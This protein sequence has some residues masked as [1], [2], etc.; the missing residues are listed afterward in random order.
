MTSTPRSPLREVAALAIPVSLEMVVALV[1][2]FI[3]Q[4]VVGGL[5]TTAIA[6]VGFANS[7]TFIVILTLGAL[8]GSVSI[9]AA[10]AHGGGR[11]HELNSLVHVA[12]FVGLGVSVLFA[13]LPAL[14]PA[15]VLRLAGG[16][17]T[18]VETGSHY[19]RFTAIGLLPLIANRV[20]AGVMRST[21]HTRG[22]LV[23]TTVATVFN[24]LLGYALVYGIGPF[25]SLG[26]VGAGVASLTASLLNLTIVCVMAY[27]IDRI[28]RWELPSTAREWWAITKPL[29]VFA[30]PLALTELVW[31]LGGY[32]YNVIFQRLGDEALAA[33]QVAGTLEAVF[34]L[35]SFGLMTAATTLIG[36]SIGQGDAGAA[37]QWVRR[38]MKAGY[39]TAAV[40]GLLY[41]AS[42]L[43]L[44]PLFP[45]VD[46]EVRHLAAVAIA[47]NAAF[48]WAKVQNMVLGGGLLPGG[49]DLKAVVLGDSVGVGVAGLPLAIGLGL[50]TPLGFIGV[51]IGRSAE[52]LLK[53]AIFRRRLRR[54]DWESLAREHGSGS[55][56]GI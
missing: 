55:G 9:M 39:A 25:P 12:L 16:S 50:F 52:E 46:V 29:F 51:L 49:N 54:I 20:I 8:G 11:L 53:L 17:P 32:F 43:I 7:I 10:R 47:I 35:A 41:L 37:R 21:G 24:T 56:E 18:V 3:N 22:P 30:A 15:A 34:I 2:N 5:G 33:A 27:G 42:I 13:L 6:A 36:R 48:Q 14:F 38:L 26:V 19:L 40:F 4:I 31:S 1:M 44:G 28:I 45:K 23:A